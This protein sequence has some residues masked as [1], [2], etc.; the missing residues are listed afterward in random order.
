M[1]IERENS[2]LDRTN[3]AFELPLQ[4]ATATTVAISFWAFATLVIATFEG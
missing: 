1:R 4:I 3:R 2:F